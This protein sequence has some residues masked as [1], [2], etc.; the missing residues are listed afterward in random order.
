MNWFK[1]KKATVD[2]EVQ[3]PE[4]KHEHMW[5]DMPW[6]MGVHYNGSNKTAG[7]TIVEPFIC[8]TCGE[9][10]DV[11]LEKEDYSNIS[12]EER[13]NIFKRVRLRYKKYLKPRAIVEDMINNILLVKDP[14]RLAMVEEMRGSP[15][16]N[17]GSSAE[18]K[19]VKDTEFKIN[20]PEREKK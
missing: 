18:M 8:V 7:Y 1:K 20:L 17:V 10:K 6:Y 12:V 11:T 16:R 2:V 15:H 3:I 19:M 9:R 5:K 13:E 4:L 14:H